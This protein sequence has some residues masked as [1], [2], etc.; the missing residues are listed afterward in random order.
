LTR[1]RLGVALRALEKIPTIGPEVV[2]AIRPEI[3]KK[4]LD[5]I[6]GPYKTWMHR[7]LGTIKDEAKL[8]RILLR[9]LQ[10][11]LPRY[12]QVRH[13]PLE[14]GKD[15]VALLDVGGVSV[16]RM[17]QAKCGDIDKAKWRESK[18]EMEEIFQVPLETL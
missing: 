16:L 3:G 12:A 15:V 6:L 13:G 18:D 5:T 17:Y 4:A 11:G 2:D 9:L 8:R 7:A 1:D 14:Y 10:S